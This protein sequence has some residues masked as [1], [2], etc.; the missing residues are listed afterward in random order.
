MR[1]TDQTATEQTAS[2]GLEGERDRLLAI[3]YGMLGSGIEAEDV[4]QEAFLR[5]QGAGS[6]GGALAA[7]LP[8]DRGDAARD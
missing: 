7:G 4:V 6:F 2:E 3:A 1:A 8:D 5:W